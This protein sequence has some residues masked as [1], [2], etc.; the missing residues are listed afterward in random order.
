MDKYQAPAAPPPEGVTPNFDNPDGSEYE[1]YSISIGMCA[2]ATLV[3]VARLYTR[4][5]ILKALGIDDCVFLVICGSPNA[6][7]SQ[8]FVSQECSALG[9]LRFLA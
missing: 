3:L 5:I 4:T 8:G 2:A 6:Y 9:R 1:I 7:V